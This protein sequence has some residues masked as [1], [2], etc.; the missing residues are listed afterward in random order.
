MAGIFPC[1]TF[2]DKSTYIESSTKVYDDVSDPLAL[3]W[4]LS[5]HTHERQAGPLV[6][7]ARSL[8]GPYHTLCSP[9]ATSTSLP[10]PEFPESPGN[11]PGPAC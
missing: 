8:P 10:S 7:P 6:L 1:P 3:G 2:K 9:P 11:S 4:S 5:T